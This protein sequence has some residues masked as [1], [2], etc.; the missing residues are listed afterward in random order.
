[1]QEPLFA[2]PLLLVDN[3]AVH[4]GNLPGRPTEAQCRNTT[5]C[6]KRFPE[7]NLMDSGSFRWGLIVHEIQ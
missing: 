7:R 6:P 4:H 1:M 3:D 2:D 5:P